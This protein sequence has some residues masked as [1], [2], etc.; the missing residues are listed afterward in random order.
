MVRTLPSLVPEILLRNYSIGRDGV[1]EILAVGVT[2][3]TETPHINF[4]IWSQF[5]RESITL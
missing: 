4:A 3:K 1:G 2:M 5:K